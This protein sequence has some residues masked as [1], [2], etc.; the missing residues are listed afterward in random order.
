M[1]AHLLNCT[2]ILLQGMYEESIASNAK[3]RPLTK[4]EVIEYCETF[5]EGCYSIT[6]I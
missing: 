3:Y 2:I 1:K 4:E 5:A 6:I